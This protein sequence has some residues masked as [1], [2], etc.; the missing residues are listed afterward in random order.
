VI[1]YRENLPLI[2]MT[3]GE[4]VAFERDWLARAISVAAQRSG[5]PNWWLAK[6][7]AESVSSWLE[8]HSTRSVVGMDE[9][10]EAV[11]DA[12]QVIGYSEIGEQFE[13]NTPFTRVSLIELAQQAGDGYELAFF[14][15]L[16]EKLNEVIRISGGYYELCGLEAC[17]K[18]L[19]KTRVW[20]RQ[21][22]ALRTDIVS[23]ARSH[24]ERFNV[25]TGQ[26]LFLY[27]A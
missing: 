18:I 16:A 12:L 24:T 7:V 9:L 22:N 19:C 1:A 23:F 27:V 13:S 20:S 5:Y 10:V 4:C 21:C 26:T 8:H 11:R 2:E 3:S 15:V 25:A 14:K 17:V 6:H